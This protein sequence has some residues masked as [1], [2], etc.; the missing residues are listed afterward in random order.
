MKSGLGMKYWMRSQLGAV[1]LY[2][3]R[4]ESFKLCW[5][6][7]VGPYVGVLYP[8]SFHLDYYSSHRKI[9]GKDCP[10]GS[11]VIS[12]R[13]RIGAPEWNLQMG[14]YG[15]CCVW[16]NLIN[17]NARTGVSQ[18]GNLSLKYVPSNSSYQKHHWHATKNLPPYWLAMTVWPGRI[19]DPACL[20]CHWDLS[21]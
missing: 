12:K 9:R 16:W 20:L 8:H 4:E 21:R 7:T 19:F 3:S 13:S 5:C 14:V 1:L 10:G 11:M 18:S 2:C 6:F 17:L 15:G